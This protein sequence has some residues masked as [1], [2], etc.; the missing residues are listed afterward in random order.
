M[1]L[2]T[3]KMMELFKQLIGSGK[4][5]FYGDLLAA[6][7]GFNR[8]HIENAIEMLAEEGYT[9]EKSHCAD[10]SKTKLTF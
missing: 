7:K 6:G 10:T 1:G 8:A 5:V 9:I 3:S 4:S 2:K